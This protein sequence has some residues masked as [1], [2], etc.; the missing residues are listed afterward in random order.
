M[1]FFVLPH[2]SPHSGPVLGPV[3]LFVL[4]LSACSEAYAAYNRP[5]VLPTSG[6]WHKSP[7]SSLLFF[8]PASPGC[9]SED[10]R[11]KGG[12]RGASHLFSSSFLED[13]TLPG[14]ICCPIPAAVSRHCVF[15]DNE[16]L[17]YDLIF[18][19]FVNICI[20]F[21]SCINEYCKKNK[22]I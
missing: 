2:L 4:I 7:L 22:L 16:L 5:H 3:L 14:F 9:N 13:H 19:F 11:H 6:S 20:Q 8:L 21:I 12:G 10:D 17:A 15:L 18:R 1:A